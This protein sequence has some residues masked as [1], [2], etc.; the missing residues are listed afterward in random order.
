MRQAL[1]DGMVATTKSAQVDSP[2]TS[3]ITSAMLEV[4][5]NLLRLATT[6]HRKLATTTA[7]ASK[8]KQAKRSNYK[9][10]EAAAA[11]S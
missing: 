7:T 5:P 11:A 3:R 8:A 2:P 10:L 1:L 4:F 6:K 9:Q